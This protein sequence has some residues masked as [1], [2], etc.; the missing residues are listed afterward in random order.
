MTEVCYQLELADLAGHYLKVQ[1]NFVPC[2]EQ[3]VQLTMPAWIPG[4]YMVR[5]FARH[6][7]DLQALDG[8]GPLAIEQLDKQSWQLIPRG[9]PVTVSYQLYAFDLS[10]RANYVNAQIAVVNPAASCLAVS[11]HQTQPCLLK[12]NRGQ[13]AASWQLACPLPRADQGGLTD[14]GEFS[15]TDYQQLIDSP[16]IA[17]DLSVRSFQLA[18]VPHHL[19]L[20][21]DTLTDIDRIAADLQPLCEQQTQVFGGLPADLR[22]YW[23]LTWVVDDGYGGLEHRNCTLL[24]CNRFDLP[25]PQQPNHSSEA[26]QNFLA[27]CSHEYFHT[28]WVKRARPKELLSYQL[29][30][31]QYTEQLWLY[32]GFTSYYDD[33]SLLRAG[34]LT[35]AD[36][37]KLMAKTI[38]RLQRAPANSRQ[39]LAD[40]SFNAWTRFY[41][42][43]EN[44]VNAVVS[45]YAKGSLVA[46]C[47]DAHL[48]AKGLS[49]DGLLQL[50]WREFGAN[51]TGSS[52]DLFFEL[53]ARYSKDAALAKQC[54]DWVTSAAPLPLESSLALIGIELNWRPPQHL[55]DLTGEPAPIAMVDPGL[56]YDA[57][58]DGL[59]LTAVRN[60]SAAHQAGLS[61]GDLII[62][63]GGLK[64]SEATWKE[65]LQRHPVG[66]KLELHYFRQQ[67]LFSCWL[68]LTEAPA[69]VAVLAA[70]EEHASWPFA[71]LAISQ[72]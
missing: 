14:F 31:E 11:T 40:S 59:L 62:A 30:E 9:K 19:V 68:Q 39:S 29:A 45:Y 20:C 43:D 58:T 42:Q 16:F 63:V 27:L 21:G 69:T 64:A 35:L 66:A 7:L 51:E 13:A 52:S 37:L 61:K 2:G 53:L 22:D 26:Y 15:A 54:R 60:D 65:L 10:V 72:E 55:H 48:Q 25:N 56:H 32:E 3:P 23:F 57:K 33:L 38:S 34:K 50:C 5:D 8:D 1:L 44:A 36:Y 6:L 47:L 41:R 28:W 70:S 67:R 12:I 18:G 24:L 49:L 46:W 17:G 4:S 71:G